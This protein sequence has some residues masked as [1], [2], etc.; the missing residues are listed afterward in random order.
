PGPCPGPVV[1]ADRE[2]TLPWLLCTDSVRRRCTGSLRTRAGRPAVYAGASQA[3]GEVWCIPQPRENAL[4]GLWE[5][6]GM[7]GLPRGDASA[8]FRLSRLHAL[9]GPQSYR[10]SEAEAQDV[11]K[12]LTAR[13][14]GDQCLAPSGA[15]HTETS[16]PLAGGGWQDTRPSHLLW[17][18]RQQ[19]RPEAIPDG[20][21]TLTL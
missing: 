5:A 2:A 14:G 1:C 12:A 21:A 4:A 18:D 17:G 3:A 20:G 19:P 11:E 8:D 7:A 9:L 6:A 15:Q 16:R 13:A 10:E